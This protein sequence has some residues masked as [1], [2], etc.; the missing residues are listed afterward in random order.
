MRVESSSQC[1]DVPPTGLLDGDAFAAELRAFDM[2]LD[3]LASVVEKKLGNH[4]RLIEALTEL[5]G[6]L[7]A[8][9]AAMQVQIETFER[10]ALSRP[11]RKRLVRR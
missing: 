4:D 8:V 6:A 2:R 10:L 5:T 3:N 7:G 11:R 9:L 1:V